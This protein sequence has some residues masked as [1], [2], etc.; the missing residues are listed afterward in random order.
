MLRT[1]KPYVFITLGIVL[2][3]AACVAAAEPN[4]ASAKPDPFQINKLLGRG[5]NMG[6]ALEAPSEGEWGVVLKEEYFR[7]YWRW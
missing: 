5:V 2:L 7:P 1:A 6:N 4:A 3:G